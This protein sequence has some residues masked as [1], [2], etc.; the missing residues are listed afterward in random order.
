MMK[1]SRSPHADSPPTGHISYISRRPSAN[2]ATLPQ[3]APDQRPPEA[4]PDPWLFD[5]EA[6]IRELDRCRE[7]VL[8]IPARTQDVHFAS[9]NAIGAL[10][11]SERRTT[12]CQSTLDDRTTHARVSVLIPQA[13]KAAILAGQSTRYRRTLAFN[14]A[15]RTPK[16]RVFTRQVS[17]CLVDHK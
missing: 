9:N 5:S 15:P 12:T 13:G 6:L 11:F 10:C 4:L 3:M 8:Q 16:L 17:Q 1:R 7:L 2:R 14:L